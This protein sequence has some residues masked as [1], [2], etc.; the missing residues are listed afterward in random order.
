M[1]T[2]RDRVAEQRPPAARPDA[3]DCRPRPDVFR[4]L[5][6]DKVGEDRRLPPIRKV[7]RETTRPDSM[8]YV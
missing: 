3:R 6:L 2:D 7:Q 8:A 1:E 5:A 4:V